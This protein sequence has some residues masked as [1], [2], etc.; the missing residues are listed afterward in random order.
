MRSLS[1]ANQL[2]ATLAI[3]PPTVID[4]QMAFLPLKS[5]CPVYQ[6]VNRHFKVD[7]VILCY[8]TTYFQRYLARVCP[9]F[10]AWFSS[11][12]FA[13]IMPPRSSSEVSLLLR[14]LVCINIAYKHLSDVTQYFDFFWTCN[15]FLYQFPDSNTLFNMEMETL[16]VLDYRLGPVYPV[17]NN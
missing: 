2:V 3:L 13:A 12:G 5:T 15:T 9:N 6:H 16:E 10:K 8:A 4:F 1:E 7:N 14:Y 17:L 11:D